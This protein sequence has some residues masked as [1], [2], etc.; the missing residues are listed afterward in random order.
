MRD[1]ERSAE[2]VHDSEMAAF[3]ADVRAQF[4]EVFTN[5]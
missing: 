1:L 5:D 4:A 2:D 3:L